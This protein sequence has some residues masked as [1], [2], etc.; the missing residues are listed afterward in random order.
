MTSQ[1]SFPSPGRQAGL[2]R[3]EVTDSGPN[4]G[5]AASGAPLDL[6][7]MTICSL[8]V[9]RGVWLKWGT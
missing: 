3:G 6:K 2:I 5:Q 1:P 7:T 9:P 8:K 4:R